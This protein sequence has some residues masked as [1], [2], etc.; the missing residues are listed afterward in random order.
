MM[1]E[2][3]RGGGGVKGVIADSMRASVTAMK[4]LTAQI[5]REQSITNMEK[6]SVLSFKK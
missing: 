2:S 5:Y 6:R 3:N 4:A 1:G